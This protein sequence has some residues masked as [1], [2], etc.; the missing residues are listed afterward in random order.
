MPVVPLHRE[1]R[2]AYARQLRQML[3][4]G[5][6][7]EP[8][9][10]P[11]PLLG[12]PPLSP[13]KRSRG[14]ETSLLGSHETHRRGGPQLAGMTG[15]HSSPLLLATDFHPPLTSSLLVYMQ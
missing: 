10:T 2:N 9:T 14:G 15:D 3:E 1:E 4:S 5:D 6:L 8:F 11:P 7:S 12:P 13:G